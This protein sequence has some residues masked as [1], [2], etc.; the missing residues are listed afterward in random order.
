MNI[1]KL[2]KLKDFLN[3]KVSIYNNETFIEKDPISIPH[4]F[5]KREDIE[6][7]GLFASIFAWGRRDIIIKKSKELL[8]YMDNQPYD[9]IMNH[10]EKDLK[11]FDNFK[12]RTFN[13]IDTLYFIKFL[14]YCYS[15]FGT[16]ENAFIRN[17]NEHDETIEK[18]LLNFHDLFF[19]LE[20]FP[21]RTKKHI[22]TPIRKSACKKLN[23]FLRWM[24]RKDNS[25]V[26]FGLWNKISPKQ[27][28]IPCDVHV[29]RVCNKLG[30]L[31]TEKVDWNT[32]LALTKQLKQ[33]N[34]KDPIIYDFAL[35]GLGI[36]NK[37]TEFQ[38]KNI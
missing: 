34:L 25:G 32:A 14:K 10:Q 37:Y 38:L 23:M 1:S 24:V 13:A 20:N 31:N 21:I 18:G 11:R 9:F 2:K 33:F 5:S 27:L 4:L 7:S 6:I 30:L 36:D 8:N 16:L 19:S 17:L 3:Q 35:F 29:I 12:H 22:S 15:S 26:D 28:I